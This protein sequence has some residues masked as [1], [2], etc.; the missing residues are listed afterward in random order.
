MSA[1]LIVVLAGAGT[2]LL[3]VS[4]VAL[5]DHVRMPAWLERTSALVSF[6]A[7]AALAASALRVPL[8]GGGMEAVRL[9]VAV[10]VAAWTARRRPVPVAFL[11]GLGALW[12]A[13]AAS[14]GW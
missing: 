11:A 2:F 4:V 6:A 12:A 7:F 10:S 8:G 5:V 14:G 9:A 13:T 1:W 3:R